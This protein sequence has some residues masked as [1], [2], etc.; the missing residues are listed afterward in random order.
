MSG[1]AALQ[2]GHQACQGR[3]CAQALGLH[4][5]VA[6]RALRLAPSHTAAVEQLPTCR[7]W[8]SRKRHRCASGVCTLSVTVTPTSS[9]RAHASS[10][11]RTVRTYAWGERISWTPVKITRSF[12]AAEGLQTVVLDIGQLGLGYQKGKMPAAMA[13]CMELGSISWSRVVPLVQVQVQI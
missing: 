9:T 8:C 12:K 3:A 4:G 2:L 1:R 7:S 6:C 13:A 11:R 10:R 5:R